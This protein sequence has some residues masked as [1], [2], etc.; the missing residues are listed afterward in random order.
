MGEP[1][2]G[3]GHRVADGGNHQGHHVLAI[4]ACSP[5]LGEDAALCPEEKPARKK[6][7]L[8]T[9]DKEQVGNWNAEC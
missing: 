1:T 7:Q 4:Q 5:D 2:Q 6:W 9:V 8:G 3:D